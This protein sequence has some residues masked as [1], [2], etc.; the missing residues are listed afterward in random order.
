M[1]RPLLSVI[2]TGLQPFFAEIRRIYFNVVWGMDIG[3]GC[4]ISFTAK[5][6]KTNPRGVHIGE[7]TLVAF[8]AVI[9]THDYVNNRH[10]EVWIGKQCYIGARSIIMPGVEVGDNSIIGA[11][12]VV[13]KNVAPG[14]LVAGNPAQIIES[15]IKTGPLGMKAAA[16]EKGVR[17]SRPAPRS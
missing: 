14:S 5:L 12:S 7:E 15:G 17:A 6:D 13:T 9:L 10:L 4:H 1:S 3:R 11:A 8:G 2:R 16:W